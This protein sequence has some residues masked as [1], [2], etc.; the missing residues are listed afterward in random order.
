MAKLLAPLAHINEDSSEFTDFI[1][2]TSKL[3]DNC[4]VTDLD[5][6][7]S[8]SPSPSS[9]SA[10]SSS[11]SSSS[12][13]CPQNSLNSGHITGNEI[14]FDDSIFDD[15]VS[16]SLE[17]LVNTFDEKITKCFRNYNEQTDQLAP[18]QV[19]SDDEILSQ[20]T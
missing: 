17:D 1:C 5:S 18:I 7:S 16:G 19:T 13:S 10:C 4:N 11:S 14:D 20:S 12:S 8:T 15:S 6:S 9:S 2:A 3:D